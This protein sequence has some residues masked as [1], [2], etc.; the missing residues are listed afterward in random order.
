MTKTYCCANGTRVALAEAWTTDRQPRLEVFA[1]DGYLFAQ[2][3]VSSL[4]CLDRADATERVR[5]S[6]LVRQH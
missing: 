2:D 5:G 1:P 6:R 4:V 3:H